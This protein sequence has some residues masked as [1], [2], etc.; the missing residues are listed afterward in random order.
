MVKLRRTEQ[1]SRFSFS[2]VVKIPMLKLCKE[3]NKAFSRLMKQV[4]LEPINSFPSQSS[5]GIGAWFLMGS[6][7]EQKACLDVA[8]EGCA[9]LCLGTVKP[10]AWDWVIS[11]STF[12]PSIL[13]CGVH[14]FIISQMT[15]EVIHCTTFLYIP[16]NR[17]HLVPFRDLFF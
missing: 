1:Y 8:T 7:W 12:G 2:Q 4:A 9:N 5:C 13:S 17:N 14:F 15:A 11:K 10:L 16:M 3:L 6:G